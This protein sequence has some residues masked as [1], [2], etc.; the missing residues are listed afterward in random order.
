MKT[1]LVQAVVDGVAIDNLRALRM[2]HLDTMRFGGYAPS[3]TYD[4]DVHS[5][6]IVEG[7]PYGIVLVPQGRV[8]I[9]ADYL[10]PIAGA[11]AGAVRVVD[12]LNDGFDI[13]G[14]LLL[15]VPFDACRFCTEK[16]AQAL[17]DLAAID[18]A[19]AATT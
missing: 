13:D 16:E 17:L 10:D 4:S 2:Q 9:L 18:A 5:V 11:I 8:W 1:E 7:Y 14:R 15:S 3:A 12:G 19:I 6:A